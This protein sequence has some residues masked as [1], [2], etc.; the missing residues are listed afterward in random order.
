MNLSHQVEDFLREHMDERRYC[1]EVYQVYQGNCSPI[2]AE[3]RLYIDSQG[4]EIPA[5]ISLRVNNGV[6]SIA[7][8]H[9]GSGSQEFFANYVTDCQ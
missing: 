6:G 2:V 4:T 7:T 8:L 9:T 1:E 3:V 5:V